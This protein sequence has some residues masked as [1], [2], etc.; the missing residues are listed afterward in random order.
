[1][2]DSKNFLSKIEIIA[3]AKEKWDSKSDQK[4]LMCGR[5]YQHIFDRLN[6][7][8]ECW[9]NNFD[10]LTFSQKSVLIKGELIRTYDGLSY[11]DRAIIRRLY[12]LE[13]FSNRWFKLSPRDKKLLLNS[14]LNQDGPG[15]KFQKG[16]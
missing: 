1:M 13:R 12:G 3:R 8:A 15:K 11:H 2:D 6:L 7:K 5:K 9:S 4:K 14:V 10:N 16:L